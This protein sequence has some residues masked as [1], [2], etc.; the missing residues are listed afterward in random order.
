MFGLSKRAFDANYD[1]WLLQMLT[2]IFKFKNLNN[3]LLRMLK[4]VTGKCLEV[5]TTGWQELSNESSAQF[6]DLHKTI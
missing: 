3:W 6:V 1:N 2:S 5:L 4:Y